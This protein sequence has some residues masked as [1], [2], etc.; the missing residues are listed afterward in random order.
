M[1]RP[2]LYST[3]VSPPCRAVLLTAEAIGLDL[4]IREVNL[5][6]KENLKD[7]FVKVPTTK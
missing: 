3:D 1:P 7:D 5:L 4:E 6:K 2:I